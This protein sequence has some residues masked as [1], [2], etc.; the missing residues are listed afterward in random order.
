MIT[1]MKGFFGL[2]KE[3][4]QNDLNNSGVGRMMMRMIRMSSDEKKIFIGDF[5]GGPHQ[6]KFHCWVGCLIGPSD[7]HSGRV[8]KGNVTKI[9]VTSG[10]ML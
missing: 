2:E 3:M 5:R 4:F 8:F 10:K 7:I 9:H 1:K 6:S